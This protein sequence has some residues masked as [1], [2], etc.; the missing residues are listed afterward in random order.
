MMAT[1]VVISEDPELDFDR[2]F[3]TS[4]LSRAH[5]LM[6]GTLIEELVIEGDL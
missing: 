4:A 1:V 3:Q 2:P 6:H 5:N